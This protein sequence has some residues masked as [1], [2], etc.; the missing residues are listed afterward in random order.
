VTIGSFTSTIAGTS[1]NGSTPVYSGT[2]QFQGFRVAGQQA[3]VDGSGVHL[4]APGKP[5]NPE[6][7]GIVNQALATTGVKIYFSAPQTIVVGEVSYH[8]A[9]SVLVYWPVPHDPN[10][11]SATVSIGGSAIAMDLASGSIP[12]AGTG[13][14]GA[15]TGGSGPAA[16]SYTGSSLAI[17]AQPT[18]P[19]LSLP[20]P[21][22]PAP[23]G[24]APAPT[25]PLR[26]AAAPALAATSRG[27]GVPWLL[28]LAACA[29]L[30]L[31]ALPLLPGLL[32]AAAVPRCERER[33][34]D[35][36]ARRP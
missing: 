27:I 18:T 10:K 22:A 17:P 14:T 9:A 23:A 34:D 15:A 29:I 25:T 35:L 21:A 24:A 33:A 11:D 32:S 8:Y 2:D 28:L 36:I 5:A 30:G 20:A 7:Q 4:G 19:A 16:P 12:P 3:Y 1:T 6:A 31:V 13:G 26:A